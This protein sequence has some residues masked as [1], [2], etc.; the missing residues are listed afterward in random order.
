[1]CVCVSRHSAE[2]VKTT[3]ETVKQALLDAKTAQATAEE[4]IAR[5]KSDIGDTENRL[6]QVTT[7][8]MAQVTPPL[9]AQVPPPPSVPG[10]HYWPR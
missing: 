2:G 1:M 8:L 3:T 10:N 7:S 5:A 6:A 9:L 4:A